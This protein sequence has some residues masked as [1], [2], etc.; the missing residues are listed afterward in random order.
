MPVLER[1]HHAFFTE[2]AQRVEDRALVEVVVVTELFKGGVDL[3]GFFV[4]PVGQH[5]H[6]VPVH[7]LRIRLGGIDDDGAVDPALLLETGMAVIPVGTVLLHREAI[8]EGLAGRDAVE[9]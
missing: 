6:V 9:R 4:A 2:V 7:R 8:S 5:H 1:L 3:L